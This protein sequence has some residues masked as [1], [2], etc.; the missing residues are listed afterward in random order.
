MR[1]LPYVNLFAQIP[2]KVNRRGAALTS[3]ASSSAPKRADYGLALQILGGTLCGGCSVA[4][5]SGPGDAVANVKHVSYLQLDNGGARGAGGCFAAE[6][7]LFW[8]EKLSDSESAITL[9][10]KRGARAL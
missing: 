1:L 3:L 6:G 8:E 5:G 4:G 7:L 9:K 10:K 2:A